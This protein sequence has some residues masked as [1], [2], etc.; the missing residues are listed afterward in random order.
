LEHLFDSALIARIVIVGLGWILKH[1]KP[2][3]GVL[4]R[5]VLNFNART[6]GNCPGKQSLGSLSAVMR[7]GRHPC[8]AP[9]LDVT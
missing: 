2:V 7:G 6:V 3:G 5:V 8:D 4:N 9:G 1:P